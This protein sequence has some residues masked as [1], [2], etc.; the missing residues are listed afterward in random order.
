MGGLSS[1][2]T[3]PSLDRL[4]EGHYATRLRDAVPSAPAILPGPSWLPSMGR[5][6][7]HPH[8]ARKLRVHQSS[9]SA[10]SSSTSSTSS[11]AS[12]SSSSFYV[13]VCLSLSLSVSL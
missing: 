8:R 13:S 12:S 3:E 4:S 1:S 10:S 11:S 2:T 7:R 6:P 5:P 9:L